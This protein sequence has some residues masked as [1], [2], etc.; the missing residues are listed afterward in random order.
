MREAQPWQVLLK[1][2]HFLP[3]LPDSHPP[4]PSSPNHPIF[5]FKLC[6]FLCCQACRLWVF[7]K[8]AGLH[9]TSAVVALPG[10]GALELSQ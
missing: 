9:G 4:P 5:H 2:M 7:W 3:E 10:A 6:A 8:P 1:K